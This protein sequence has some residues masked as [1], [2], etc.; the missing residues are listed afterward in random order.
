METKT[1]RCP[2]C[3]NPTPILDLCVVC[4]MKYSEL[5]REPYA[6]IPPIFSPGSIDR[7]IISARIERFRREQEL[8]K[9]T[10]INDFFN[11]DRFFK[12]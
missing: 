9:S 3:F 5:L 4:R 6:H 7:E 11:S 8:K 2:N 1:E 12:K 10:L